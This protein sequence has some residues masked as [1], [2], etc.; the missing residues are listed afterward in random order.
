M[1]ITVCVEGCECRDGICLDE[2]GN[3]VLEALA[4]SPAPT[5]TP[6]PVEIS[7]PTP[8][9]IPVLSILC[10]PNAVFS[11]CGSA[12]PLRCDEDPT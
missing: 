10:G 7:I 3:C 8:P 1:C 11:T 4:I 12:C 2:E 6:T 5:P 9:A